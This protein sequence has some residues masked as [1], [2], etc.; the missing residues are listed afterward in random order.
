M[1][2]ILIQETGK[3]KKKEFYDVFK[4]QCIMCETVEGQLHVHH[5][6]Y[7]DVG[8]EKL[9]Q[10]VCLCEKCHEKIH[11]KKGKRGFGIAK[12]VKFIK[13]DKKYLFEKEIKQLVDQREKQSKK[14][15]ASKKNKKG[16]KPKN[17]IKIFISANGSS[18]A[19]YYIRHSDDNTKVSE[20]LYTQDEMPVK[21]RFLT[22]ALDAIKCLEIPHQITIVTSE[23]TPL[24]TVSSNITK[25][26]YEEILIEIQNLIKE[27]GHILTYK[28]KKSETDAALTSKNHG[29]SKKIHDEIAIHNAGS[30][31]KMKEK[32][33]EKKVDT[34]LEKEALANAFRESCTTKIY[35][36][37]KYN[38]TT[39]L[40]SYTFTIEQDG[41]IVN[42]ISQN[43]A[44]ST[45][46]R[47]MIIAAIDALRLL[48]DSCNV[49]IVSNTLLGISTTTTNVVSSKSINS[50][51]L[52]EFK[53]LA[54]SKK[55]KFIG[56][57]VIGMGKKKKTYSD[58]R[59]ISE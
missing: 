13:E 27:S 43:F 15:K 58:T 19:R 45:D 49:E 11:Q 7:A 35:T 51:L 34:K 1:R 41:E 46:C 52:M 29:I 53:D 50:D 10:L 28:A 5:T 24:G 16:A 9:S 3:I 26:P 22:I 59:L 48:E 2:I 31:A 40:G 54:D 20:K 38:Y 8:N 39:N 18:N 25:S 4:R 33:L 12:R 14:D 17:K 37:S 44:D 36:N 30:K 57:L 47:L 56:T 32:R 23:K 6:T 21:Q 55:I 42:T